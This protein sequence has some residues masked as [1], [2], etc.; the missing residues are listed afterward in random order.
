MSYSSKLSE[1]IEE[2]KEIDDK[3]ERLEMVFDLADEVNLLPP[4]EWSEVTRVVGCQSEA[5]VR[6]DVVDS[7]VRLESGAD[8]KLVQGLM[9]ILTLAIHGT[10]VTKALKLTPDFAT[11]MGVLNTLSP[12]RSNGF[13]NMFDKVMREI[14][15]IQGD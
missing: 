3:M 7:L 14:E 1:L 5:H 8:S 10:E 6:V 4:Q 12:S 13:R 2:F 11:E 9:G 15:Q